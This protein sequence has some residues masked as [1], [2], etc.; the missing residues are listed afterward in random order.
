VQPVGVG[1]ADVDPD[2][3]AA[4]EIADREG[5]L[6]GVSQPFGEGD[7]VDVLEAVR[8]DAGEEVFLGFGRV[9]CDTIS[10]VYIVA[11]WAIVQG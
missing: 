2:P 8:Q 9:A 1:C 5:W 10:N 11:L 4:G 7:P 6:I 3:K